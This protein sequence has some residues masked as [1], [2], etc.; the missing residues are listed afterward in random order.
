MS[1]IEY[2]RIY[3]KIKFKKIKRNK[4]VISCNLFLENK[5]L[6]K[7]SFCYNKNVIYKL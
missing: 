3:K 6:K 7:F 1:K 2:A 4:N 5:N